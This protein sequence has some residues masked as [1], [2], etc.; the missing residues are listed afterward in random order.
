MESEVDIDSSAANIARAVLRQQCEAA[1]RLANPA[2]ADPRPSKF[3]PPVVRLSSSSRRRSRPINHPCDRLPVSD[4]DWRMRHPPRAKPCTVEPSTTTKGEPG[5]VPR[6]G[7]DR[8]GI[9]PAGPPS[10]P[11]GSSRRLD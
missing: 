3:A 9:I 10:W 4:M 1:A 7:I 5:E 8:R 2:H 6:E 11:L